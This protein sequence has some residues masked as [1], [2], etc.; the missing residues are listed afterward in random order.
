MFPRHVRGLYDSPPH[1]RPGSLGGKQFHGPG[2][3]SL[4]CVQSRDLVLCIPAS[5]AVAE[6]GLL[7]AWA[8]ASE[9][10]SPKPWQ[11]PYGFEPAKA[12]KSR[13]G[14]WELLP[15]FQRIYGNAWISRQKFA[16]G[17]GPLWKISARACR[18]EM[19]GQSPHIE[20]PLGHCLVEL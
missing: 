19:L 14:V 3:V 13:I 5:L 12:Q 4:C 8:R 10:E 9:G 20:S 15:R 7:R 6:R 11:L 2:L 17:V 1:H 16:A 18:R